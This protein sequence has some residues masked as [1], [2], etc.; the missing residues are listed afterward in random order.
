M[1]VPGS[2]GCY[3][4]H[5]CTGEAIGKLTESK[6]DA[7]NDDASKDSSGTADQHTQTA[8][9]NIHIVDHQI[10]SSMAKE[11]KTVCESSPTHPL[12][13]PHNGQSSYNH[14]PGGHNKNGNGR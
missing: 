11:L 14:K 9:R 10:L 7:D 13:P 4:I 3:T 5:G 2:L 12:S 1:C 6:V 8:C